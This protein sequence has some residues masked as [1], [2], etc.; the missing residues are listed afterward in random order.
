[1]LKT[2]TA[3]PIVLRLRV[4]G[5]TRHNLH[6]HKLRQVLIIPMEGRASTAFDDQR[7]AFHVVLSA[8]KSGLGVVDHHVPWLHGRDLGI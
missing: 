8:D 4:L 2:E 6:R 7:I 5:L 1:L 3:R